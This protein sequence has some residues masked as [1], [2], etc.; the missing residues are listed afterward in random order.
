MAYLG[1]ILMALGGVPFIV[2]GFD[3]LGQ[4]G[5][6]GAAFRG[7]GWMSVGIGIAILGRA[8]AGLAEL[9]DS[10]TR[11]VVYDEE[12]IE[13][14]ALEE[15]LDD[16]AMGDPDDPERFRFTRPARPDAD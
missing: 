12:A 14:A 2:Y 1:W 7:F 8:I 9:Y 13:E 15:F 11:Q 5:E 6:L 3:A 10:D 16:E 4:T